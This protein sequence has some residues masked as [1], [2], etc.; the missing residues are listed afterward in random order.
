V[1]H[2]GDWK[3]VDTAQYCEQKTQEL[4]LEMHGV[5]G[6]NDIAVQDFLHV[7]RKASKQFN[8]VEGTLEL[9][10]SDKRI[11]VYHGHH[12]P[13]RQKV[14][15]NDAYDVV[16]L[17][18]THKPLIVNEHKKLIINPGSTA[19]AIPRSKSWLPSVALLDLKTMTA[20]IH[21]LDNSK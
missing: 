10:L 18:H 20:E 14:V 9:T 4:S 16:L 3:S 17:G 13:T 1:I 7:S 2:C 8:I 15:E 12:A 21:F 5:L 6:N 11:A 19:F